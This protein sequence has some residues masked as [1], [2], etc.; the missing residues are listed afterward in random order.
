MHARA[1]SGQLAMENNNDNGINFVEEHT[2]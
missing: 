1:G 2:I